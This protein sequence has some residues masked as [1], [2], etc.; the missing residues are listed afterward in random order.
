MSRAPP[1]TPK[2]PPP[3]DQKTI[4]PRKFLVTLCDPI[5]KIPAAR[6]ISAPMQPA[7]K[8]DWHRGVHLARNHRY[9]DL[10]YNHQWNDTGKSRWKR[11][12]T[13]ANKCRHFGRITI[14]LVP[15]KVGSKSYSKNKTDGN[16]LRKSRRRDYKS[17]QGGAQSCKGKQRYGISR[18][19]CQWLKNLQR[20]AA[21]KC[22]V[23]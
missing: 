18:G 14:A 6:T 22:P 20:R 4:T 2:T 1:I 17:E 23:D 7:P 13:S 15:H 21:A 9:V 16:S 3:R 5:S 11:H 10:E 19:L 12:S 8:E